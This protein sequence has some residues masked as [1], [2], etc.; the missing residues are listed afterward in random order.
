MDIQRSGH[1]IVP[2]WIVVNRSS[3]EVNIIRA[4]PSCGLSKYCLLADANSFVG[5]KPVAVPPI[6]VAI[7]VVWPVLIPGTRWISI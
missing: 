7:A 3:L 1:P 4:K 2:A 5:A 6:V